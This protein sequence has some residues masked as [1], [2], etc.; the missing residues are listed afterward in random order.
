VIN[1]LNVEEY[2]YGVVPKEMPPQ[3][4]PEALKAQDIAAR[5]YA[6]YQKEKNTNRDYDVITST[7]SQVYGGAVVETEKSNQ[8]VDETKG[9]SLLY[10]E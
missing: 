8:A 4:H 2:L 5:T 6:L 7:T 10:N 3:W 1:I 9:K